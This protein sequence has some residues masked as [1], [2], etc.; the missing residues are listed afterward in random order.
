MHYAG[1]EVLA[2]ALMDRLG[3]EFEFVV[4]CLDGIGELGEKLRAQGQAVY[5][6]GRR[7]GVDL[8]VARRLGAALHEHRVD[9]V[10]A[11][12]YTPFFYAAL[13]RRGGWGA[14]PPI[15]F[16]EHGRHYP[17]P[18]KWKHVAANRL[19]LKRDDRAT[20]L[21]TRL[22]ADI[23]DLARTGVAVSRY[24]VMQAVGLAAALLFLFWQAAHTAQ[25]EWRG[26]FSSSSYG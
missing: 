2:A 15:L 14:T 22:G 23:L 25:R 7:P 13:A 19:L 18:R 24:T 5:E 20:A 3:G 21:E 16:T 10:H 17:D 1:A 11:H 4:L 12:Q 6:L 26:R 9:L 8:G